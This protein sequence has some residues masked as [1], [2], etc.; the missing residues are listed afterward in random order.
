MIVTGDFKFMGVESRRSFKDPS[1]TN[2][3]LG[4]SQGLDTVRLYIDADM[5]AHF[6]RLDPYSDVT[7]ELEYNP[8]AERSSYAMR[9]HDLHVK[10]V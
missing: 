10:E 9:L 5:F 7:A 6:S 8:A 1:K 2:Y 3:I 4:L